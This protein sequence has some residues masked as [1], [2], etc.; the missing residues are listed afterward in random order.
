MR[1]SGVPDALLDEIDTV[2]SWPATRQQVT[3]ASKLVSDDIVQMIAAAGTPEEGRAKVA[4]YVAA[5]C[6]SPILYP[7]GPDVRF[8]IDTFADWTPPRS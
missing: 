4:E 8:M 7:L 3:D 5:G 6:T 2:L 1:A